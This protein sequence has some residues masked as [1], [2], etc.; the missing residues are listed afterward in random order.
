MNEKI[1]R[2]VRPLSV[3]GMPPDWTIAAVAGVHYAV[4]RCRKGAAVRNL[5]EALHLG[6]VRRTVS[7]SQETKRNPC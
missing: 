3:R 7:V 5:L 1:V 6:T 4:W 2:E